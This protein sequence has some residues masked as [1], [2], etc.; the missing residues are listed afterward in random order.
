[1]TQAIPYRINEDKVFVQYLSM[2]LV[3]RRGIIPVCS[4]F[5]QRMSTVIINLMTESIG[6]HVE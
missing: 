4:S 2:M 5:C 1:M 3:W 6:C